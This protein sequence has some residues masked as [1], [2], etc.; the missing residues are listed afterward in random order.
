LHE[1]ASARR[2]AGVSKLV[3]EGLGR[4]F[5]GVRGGKPVTAL[6]PTDLTIDRKSVV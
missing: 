1:Q 4:I 5:P 2:E 6:R 3:V